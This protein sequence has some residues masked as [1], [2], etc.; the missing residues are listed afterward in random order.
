[1][2]ERYILSGLAHGIPVGKLPLILERY[3]LEAHSLSSVEKSLRNLKKHC[4]CN[5]NAQLV[6]E[7]REWVLKLDTDQILDS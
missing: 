1:M 7:Y 5:T 6:Y 3:D 4:G 2:Y